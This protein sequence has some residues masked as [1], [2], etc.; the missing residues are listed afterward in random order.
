MTVADPCQ[1]DFYVLADRTVSAEL[2]VC[3][4]ALM[5]WE[6]GHRTAVV[7]EDEAQARYWDSL[8]W[9]IPEGRFLPHKQMRHAGAAPVTIGTLAEVQDDTSDVIIN[10]TG[11]AVPSPERFRRLLELVPSD[12]KQR[13]ASRD[14]FRAYRQLGLKP[15][16]HEIN[17]N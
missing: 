2:L 8:M 11:K 13:K 17:H 1:I 10:L 5:A 9:E 12:D 6:H 4:L 16:S 15:E 3:R 14:K 7:V